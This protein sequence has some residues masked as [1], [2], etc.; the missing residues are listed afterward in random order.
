MQPVSSQPFP[1]TRFTLLRRLPDAEDLAAWESFVGIYVPV[2]CA[3]A[4]NRGCS[5]EE[6]GE[7]TKVVMIRVAERIGEFDP[8]AASGPFRDWLFDLV[9]EEFTSRHPD[10]VAKESPKKWPETTPVKLINDD[11][12]RAE[13]QWEKEYRRFAFR[14]AADEMV[15]ELGAGQPW[16]I[17]R[18]TILEREEPGK[19]AADLGITLGAVYMARSR[20]LARMRERISAIEVDWESGA[21]RMSERLG[22]E[23]T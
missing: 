17:F 3:F 5:P 21:A 6:A 2:V 8:D 7:L 19:V 18:R 14:R 15:Q 10:R 22:E 20:V 4:V 9:M 13:E 16:E 12:I 11:S 1:N 23:P